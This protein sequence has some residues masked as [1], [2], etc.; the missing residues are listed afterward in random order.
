VPASGAIA[1]N[2]SDSERNGAGQGGAVGQNG[3]S[4]LVIITYLA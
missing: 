1:G 2:P 3:T 4:G